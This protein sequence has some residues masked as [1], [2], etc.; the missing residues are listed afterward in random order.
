MASIDEKNPVQL[1][2]FEERQI[3]KDFED[4]LIDNLLVLDTTLDTISSLLD[5]YQSYWRISR[6]QSREMQTD[7][8]DLISVAL[9]EQKSEVSSSRRKIETLH[10]KV[11]GSIKLVRLWWHREVF[12]IFC[13]L[14]CSY[15]VFWT[16]AM[17]IL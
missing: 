6:L 16:W 2:N 13:L 4:L 1:L 17:G 11:Q 10:R 8:V 3:L 15:P 12:Y 5:N 9:Q 7:D 14:G